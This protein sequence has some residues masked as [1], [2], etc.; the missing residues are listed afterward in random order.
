MG[1]ATWPDSI[2]KKNLL[3]DP[4]AA[5]FIRQISKGEKNG[6]LQQSFSDG[7]QTVRERSDIDLPGLRIM[8]KSIRLQGLD[9]S[10]FIKGKHS[11]V[12]RSLK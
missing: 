2:K 11:Q 4:D 1:Y 8:F 3:K 9:W 7:E 12:R 10:A 6:S 5:G